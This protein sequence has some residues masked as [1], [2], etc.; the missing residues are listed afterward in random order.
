MSLKKL[1][2]VISSRTEHLLARRHLYGRGLA[3][4]KCRVTRYARNLP[5]FPFVKRRNEENVDEHFSLLWFLMK[6]ESI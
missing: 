1:A 2:E 4:L 5:R 3:L 6:V